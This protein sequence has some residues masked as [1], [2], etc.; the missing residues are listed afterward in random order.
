MFK[1]TSTSFIANFV[2]KIDIII[3]TKLIVI[4]FSVTQNST[5]CISLT[6]YPKL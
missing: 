6:I 5:A 3:S 2:K 4:P 1:G